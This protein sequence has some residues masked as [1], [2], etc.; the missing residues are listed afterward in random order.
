MCPE[1]DIGRGRRDQQTE[2]KHACNVSEHKKST[3]EPIRLGVC[4]SPTRWESAFIEIFQ[5]LQG[6]DLGPG[7]SVPFPVMAKR[8]A[9]W[10]I[11]YLPVFAS[12][13][14]TLSLQI[15]LCIFGRNLLCA[16][17]TDATVMK[18]VA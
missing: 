8:G 13:H 7:T 2:Q 6:G 15:C 14:T 16:R 12:I 9:S 1:E 5:I 10:Q 18:L 17:F 4:Q 11:S 3:S